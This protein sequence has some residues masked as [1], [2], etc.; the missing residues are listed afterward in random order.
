MHGNI[1]AVAAR[2]SRSKR[3]LEYRRLNWR[4]ETMR[5][6]IEE[7]SSFVLSAREAGFP[8]KMSVDSHDVPNAG[9][10]ELT[11][12]RQPTDALKRQYISAFDRD[13]EEFSD[14]QVFEEGGQLVASQSAEGHVFF[15][16]HPRRSEWCEPRD[17]AYII[18]GPFEPTDVTRRVVQKM[19][20]RH[21]IVVRTSSIFGGPRS[22]TFRERLAYQFI[23][24]VELRKRYRLIRAL[25][26]LSN[27]WGKAF[28]AAA[29][30]LLVSLVSV[31]FTLALQRDQAV[32][33]PE[34]LNSCNSTRL[35]A[36]SK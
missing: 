8:V 26:T 14:R 1:Q 23:V 15:V 34:A 32:C 35:H 19:I 20:R 17:N 21:L 16:S 33:V 6:V 5:R 12:E 28:V 18:G 24:L 36:T 2:L 31:A 10:V 27:E 25:M 30:A 9:L 7:F 4:V 22:L 13:G 3:L 29:L 11:L